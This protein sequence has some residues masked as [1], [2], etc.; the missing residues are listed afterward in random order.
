[1]LGALSLV[2]IFMMFR[3]PFARKSMSSELKRIEKIEKK[4]GT[5]LSSKEKIRMM[6]R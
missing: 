2:I 1:M 6:R 4:T 3:G 5:K